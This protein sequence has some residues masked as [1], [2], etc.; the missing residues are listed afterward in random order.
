M[1]STVDTWLLM[2]DTKEK[3]LGPCITYKDGIPTPH[4]GGSAIEFAAELF[5]NIL[6]P[7]SG[8]TISYDYYKVSDK[9]S[10]YIYSNNYN[11]HKN[12]NKTIPYQQESSVS[13]FC[14]LWTNFFFSKFFLCFLSTTMVDEFLFLNIIA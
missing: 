4:H 14:Y 13:F 5:G 12:T 11:I 10:D 1:K 6:V 7:K 8:Q 2:V 3:T 9:N